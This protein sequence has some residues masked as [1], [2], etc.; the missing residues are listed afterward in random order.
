MLHVSVVY[1]AIDLKDHIVYSILFFDSRSIPVSSTMFDQV[2]NPCL[3]G[4]G[5]SRQRD[6]YFIL[7]DAFVL[8]ISFV[9]VKLEHNL[10]ESLESC[11]GRLNGVKSVEAEWS[12]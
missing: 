5:F 7:F 12:N 11:F 1:I 10:E 2:L 8:E 9:Y 6:H 3:L 4:I